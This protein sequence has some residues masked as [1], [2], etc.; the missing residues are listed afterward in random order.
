MAED[1]TLNDVYKMTK[2]KT[3]FLND[4]QSSEHSQ[5]GTC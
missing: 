1:F 2:G 3:K 4:G 5:P